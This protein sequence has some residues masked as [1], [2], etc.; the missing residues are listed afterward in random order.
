M[1]DFSNSEFVN[2]LAIRIIYAE[3]VS[4]SNCNVVFCPKML[5]Y[6]KNCFH[7]QLLNNS[8]TDCVLNDLEFRLNDKR[9]KLFLLEKNKTFFI[10]TNIHCKKTINMLENNLCFSPYIITLQQ[11]YKMF[12]CIFLLYVW[13]KL[14]IPQK[15]RQTQVVSRG[16]KCFQFKTKLF[17]LRSFLRKNRFERKFTVLYSSKLRE[18]KRGKTRRVVKRKRNRKKKERGRERVRQ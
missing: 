5:K 1:K 16:L 6:K 14:I 3:I 13:M 7:N 8:A 2:L 15:K 17:S 9:A 4:F 18:R 11:H 12:N 10:K